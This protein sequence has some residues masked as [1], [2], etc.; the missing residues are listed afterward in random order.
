MVNIV[1]NDVITFKSQPPVRSKQILG[2][3]TLVP[4]GIH[5]VIND[6]CHQWLHQTKVLEDLVQ[7]KIQYIV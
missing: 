4:S 6:Q 1:L 5:D 2:L 3:D 7:L